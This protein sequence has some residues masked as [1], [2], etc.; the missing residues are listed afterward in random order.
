M[1]HVFTLAT[2]PRTGFMIEGLLAGAAYRFPVRLGFG[3][4]GLHE[5]P[6]K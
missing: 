1:D 3:R 2:V 4:F 5:R 6:L